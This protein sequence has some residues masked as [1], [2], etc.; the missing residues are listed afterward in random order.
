MRATMR[1]LCACCIA[2]MTATL[3]WPL[4]AAAKDLSAREVIDKA[5]WSAKLDGAE[6]INTLTIINA[7]GQK[8]VRKTAGISKL[9]DGGQTEKRLIRFLKPADVKGTGL[10]SYDYEKKDDDIW[11]FLPSLRKTRRIVSSEK[12]KNFMGSEFTYADITPPP[13]DDFSYKMLR[14]EKAGGVECYVIE[15]KPKNKT[16]AEEN[17]YSK[18]VAW[19]GKKDFFIRKAVSHDLKGKLHKELK[20]EGIKEIDTVKHRYRAMKMTMVNK[21]NGRSSTMEVNKIKLRADIPDKCFT[22]R[23]LERI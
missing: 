21:Q 14:T 3:A 22:T 18:R 13:V 15:S 20:A 8:R 11:F 7:K 6:M 23:Y 16:V 5:W 2:V 12:A 19:F 9:Y 1:V 10:L 4:S 17:G